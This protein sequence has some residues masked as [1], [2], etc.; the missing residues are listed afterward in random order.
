MKIV[1]TVTRILVGLLFIFSGLVKAND[2]QGLSYKMQEFFELWGMLEFNK[3]TLALS[4]IINAFEI[5]AG[6]A[7]LL[8]WRMKIFSWLLLLLILFFTFLTGYAFYSGKFKNCGCFGDCLPISPGASFTKDI[9]LSALILFLF[10]F[11]KRIIPAFSEK[12]SL[13]LMSLV[14][15]FSFGIQFYVLK[16]LPFVDCLPYKKNNNISEK[17]KIPVGAVP[18]SFAIRFLY[19]KGGQQYE[20]DIADLPA[21]I[22]TY[23]FKD[24]IDK[25]VRKGNAE[26]PIKGFNLVTASNNDTTDFILS[27]PKALLL[28]SENFS[29]PVSRW[30]NDFDKIYTTALEKKVPVFIV[31]SS[32]Q[33]AATAL[34]GTK[35]TS[36]PI[37]KCD[38]TAIR[39]AARTDPTLYV[40]E[41]GTIKGK[42]S[43]ADFNE[44]KF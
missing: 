29:T 15:I 36:I 20:F 25:L 19:E 2:P 21:D 39:T 33:T 32:D 35:F 22:E 17:M 23:T 26:P 18:D 27:Q 30:S 28:F 8:G 43:Y 34:K 9:I 5:I 42:W 7:L 24:R 12:I 1:L 40:L 37:L 31:T 11:R 44:V 38:F 4:V 10:F 6:F 14:T 41:N 16:H 13:L 3:Y